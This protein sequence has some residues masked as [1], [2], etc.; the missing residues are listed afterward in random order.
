MEMQI[1]TFLIT[2]KLILPCIIVGFVALGLGIP[3]L[4]RNSLSN[5]PFVGEELGSDE[6]RRAAYMS[7]GHEMYI[8]GLQKVGFM[9][10]FMVTG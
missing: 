8:E 7:N 10:L 1:L 3:L 2:A 4:H 5:I 9:L 6:K